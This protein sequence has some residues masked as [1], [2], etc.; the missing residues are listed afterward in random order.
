VGFVAHAGIG[1]PHHRE[2]PGDD[3]RG[4]G[5]SVDAGGCGDGVGS[6]GEG[7]AGSVDVHGGAATGSVRAVRR[8]P[9]GGA[10]AVESSD[11]HHGALSGEPAFLVHDPTIV[12]GGQH[13]AGEVPAFS[14]ITVQALLT[15]SAVGVFRVFR[16]TPWCSR[17]NLP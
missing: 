8:V 14:Q 11:D 5:G 7:L 2:H 17:R 9:V 6:Q 10:G 16:F 12:A 3:G 13:P 4:E 1:V 15:G